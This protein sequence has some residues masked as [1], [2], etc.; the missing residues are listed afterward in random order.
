MQI[1]RTCSSCLKSG[2]VYRYLPPPSPFQI[3]ASSFCCQCYTQTYILATHGTRTGKTSLFA[4]PAGSWHY[5]IG[6]LQDASDA[7]A[8]TAHGPPSV[9]FE[10]VTFSFVPGS[11]VLENGAAPH[12]PPPPCPLD[13]QLNNRPL[14]KLSSRHPGDRVQTA[15]P[16]SVCIDGLV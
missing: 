6:V 8:L 12:A 13:L 1:W 14:L 16:G 3:R 15:T 11:T 10:D 5:A 9:E 4:P 7:K 2:P